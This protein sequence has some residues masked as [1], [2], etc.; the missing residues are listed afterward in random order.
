MTLKEQIDAEAAL[1]THQR[2]GFLMEACVDD[3]KMRHGLWQ[4]QDT[5]PIIAR[6]FAARFPKVS[7]ILVN[8][9]LGVAGKKEVTK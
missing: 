9:F 5:L 1:A 4:P 6:M 8:A 2:T 3:A 7:A